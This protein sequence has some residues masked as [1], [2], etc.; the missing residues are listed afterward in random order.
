MS[1]A[2]GARALEQVV[3]EGKKEEEVHGRAEEERGRLSKSFREER[4]GEAIPLSSDREGG[5]SRMHTKR[6]EPNEFL[7][8]GT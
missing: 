4:R 3:T 2:L 5:E 1:T 7:F 6:I 8:L